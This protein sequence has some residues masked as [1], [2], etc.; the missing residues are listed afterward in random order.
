MRLG[1]DFDNTFADFGA[2][3]RQVTLERTGVDLRAIREANPHAVDVEALVHAAIGRE[4]FEALILEVLHD[5]HSETIEPR[6]G[7]L[8]VARRLSDRHELVI[9]TARSQ[10]ESVTPRRWLARHGL[11]VADFIATDYGPKASHALHLGLAVHLDDNVTVFADFDEAHPT[12]PALIEH[13]MN[14]GRAR[15]AHWRSVEDW[16][17]FERLVTSLEQER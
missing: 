8:E 13:P 15:A 11:N 10:R 9:V 12:I 3:L 7:A 6:P 17:A 16:L 5:D 4:R 14:L 2:L 1:I